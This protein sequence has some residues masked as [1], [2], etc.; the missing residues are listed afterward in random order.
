MTSLS[1]SSAAGME[2]HSTNRPP[3][4]DGTNYQFL[5]NRMSIYMRS[6]DYEMWDVVM[7][8]PYVPTKI[9]RENGKLEPKLRSEWTNTETKKV[10]INFK[11]IN[12][13]NCALNPMEFNRISTCESVKEI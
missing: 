5:S 1:S 4:F 3:L 9:E 11:A 6:C 8:D 7:N 13:F 12:T 2:G 10:Q